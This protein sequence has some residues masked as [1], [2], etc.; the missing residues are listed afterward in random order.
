MAG[1]D[2]RYVLNPVPLTVDDALNVVNAPVDA[3]VEPMAGGLERSNVP[4]RVTVPEDVIGPPVNVMPFTV[5]DVATDVTV[6][7]PLKVFQSVDVKYPLTDVVA[8]AMLIAGVVPPEDTTGAVP[9][10]LVTVPPD[11]GLVFVTVKLG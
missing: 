8:A 10:T 1:G 4:P 2:A 7:L 11:E 5:P 3:A 9:V 6:P